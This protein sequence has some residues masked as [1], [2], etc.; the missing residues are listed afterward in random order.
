MQKPKFP[1]TLNIKADE[2]LLMINML[3]RDGHNAKQILSFIEGIDQCLTFQ[4]SA[5]IIDKFKGKKRHNRSSARDIIYE[6][7]CKIELNA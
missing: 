2:G 3:K 4:K 7:A 6:R 5:A 1:G